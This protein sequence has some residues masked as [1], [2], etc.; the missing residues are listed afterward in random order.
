MLQRNGTGGRPGQLVR[1][2]EQ[3]AAV[4]LTTLHAITARLEA[5]KAAG[6]LSDY[7]VAWHGRGGQLLPAVTVWR[8]AGLSEKAVESYVSRLL[9]GLVAAG[10]IF[11][12]RT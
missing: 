8:A 10:N 3:E 2:Q 5:S 9:V 11:V 12:T 4:D 6:W 1:R 7:L